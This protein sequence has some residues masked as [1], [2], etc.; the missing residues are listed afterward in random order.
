MP[1]SV[2]PPRSTCSTCSACSSRLR[3]RLRNHPCDHLCGRPAAP[4]A[5]VAP[6]AAD[7]VTVCVITHTT[8]RHLEQPLQARPR[9]AAQARACRRPS[10]A[11][12]CLGAS[13]CTHA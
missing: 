7:C 10:A 12:S 2:W 4:A 3:N 5:P 6:V 8:A 13:G 1:P 9:E 11:P